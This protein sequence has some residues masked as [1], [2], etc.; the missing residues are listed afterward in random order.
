MGGAGSR[1]LK[2]PH[3][4]KALPEGTNPETAARQAGLALL[5]AETMPGQRYVGSSQP[6]GC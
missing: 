4:C 1:R 3:G 6:K 5:A 2:N